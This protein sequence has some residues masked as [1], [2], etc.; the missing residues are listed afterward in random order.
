M[1]ACG[2]NVRWL[3]IS[4]LA[5]GALSACAARAVCCES[6]DAIA[7]ATSLVR[8]GCYDCLLEARAVYEELL[9]G[10][11]R[12]LARVSLFEVE[13]LI[14]LREKELALDASGALARARATA[15]ELA[16]DQEPERLLAIVEAVP[17]D[18]PG[19]PRRDRP[20]P[21]TPSERNERDREASEWLRDA[22]AF[23][24]LRNYLSII[25]ECRRSDPLGRPRDTLAPQPPLLA[26]RW[27]ICGPYDEAALASVRAAEPRFRDAALFQARAAMGAMPGSDGSRVRGFLDEAY[28]HFPHSPAVTYQ[29]ATVMQALGECRSAVDA[30]TET[31]DLRERHE[32][33]RLGRAIC[34]TYLGQARE[35]IADATA[36]IDASDVPA[37]LYADAHYWRAWNRHQLEQL[38]LARADIDRAKTLLYNTRVLTLAGMIE[39]DQKDLETAMVDLERAKALDGDN[40][41]AR[42]YLGLVHA[43]SEHWPE[44]ANAFASAADCYERAAAESEIAR[45]TLLRQTDL[46]E[47]FRE[48]QLVGFDT[49]IRQDRAR[50]AT[51]TFNAAVAYTRAR[52][53]ENALLYIN[54]A[55]ADPSRREALEAL[56]SSLG[57][58]P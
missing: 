35:A 47:Q 16:L 23:P 29:R 50:A 33:A 44:T 55:S 36:L 40:C 24:A 19:T 14:A 51:S 7:R 45:L 39:Y 10:R 58:I 11:D 42:W 54:R 27:A 56:R 52:D 37:A 4:L 12:H 17:P 57:A 1:P 8:A 5:S 6:A 30:Y 25:L 20:A 46:A 18:T 48:R 2:R 31:L 15:G 3:T 28:E 32:D 38:D 26:Y 53:R 9:G 21:V 22:A 49:A 34:L 13:L 43:A 41:A